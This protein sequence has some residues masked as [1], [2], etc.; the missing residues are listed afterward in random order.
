MNCIMYAI[1]HVPTGNFLNPST[2]SFS[3]SP[4]R[5]FGRLSDA[6][7]SLNYFKQNV[8]RENLISNSYRNHRDYKVVK[9]ELEMVK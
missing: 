5:F 8:V 1:V 7:N 3:Q 4:R 9:L 2:L 6:A